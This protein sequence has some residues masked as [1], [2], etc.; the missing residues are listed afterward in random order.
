MDS[1][2]SL[3]KLP[4]SNVR[5]E[6]NG[7]NMGEE[8]SE[9]RMSYMPEE[10]GLEPSEWIQ[11]EVGHEQGE[12]G[13][14]GDEVQVPSE[15]R[16]KAQSRQK[17]NRRCSRIIM[18]DEARCLKSIREERQAKFG[19]KNYS[20]RAVAQR[21]GRTDSWLAHIENGR[22]DVPQDERLENLLKVYGLKRK[23][24]YEKVRIYKQKKT[25]QM[26][27]FE[28]VPHLND[29]TI[30]LILKFTYTLIN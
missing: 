22:A 9:S 5:Y 19:V 25:P 20:L 14:L 15:K 10:R 8:N 29:E 7:G 11:R 30:K 23:S 2:R 21:V 3:P 17:N 12:K 16:R 28:I 6:A 26:E 4:R 18:T 27:I 13:E 1:T 24:F